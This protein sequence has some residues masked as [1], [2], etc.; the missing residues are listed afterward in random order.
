[1]MKVLSG[2]L[3]GKKSMDWDPKA[4]HIAC[5]NHVINLGVDDFMKSIKAFEGGTQVG[6]SVEGEKGEESEEDEGEEDDND[7]DG[8]KGAAGDR[9]ADGDSDEDNEENE[10][11]EDNEVAILDGPEG[12][13]RTV[14]KIRK[15]CV[16]PLLSSPLPNV[17]EFVLGIALRS[18]KLRYIY[19]TLLIAE[20]QVF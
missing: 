1:M 4:H 13:V 18:T 14:F 3:K 8:R 2:I 15:T 12:M 11:N 19:A 17:T 16:V 9:I 7:G 5:L 6:A 10:D 20:N